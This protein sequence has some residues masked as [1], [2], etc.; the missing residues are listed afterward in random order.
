MLIWGRRCRP[1]ASEVT[2]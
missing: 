1:S 2:T